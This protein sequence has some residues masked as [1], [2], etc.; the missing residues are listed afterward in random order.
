MVTSA[1]GPDAAGHL[2]DLTQHIPFEMVDE[3]LA[4]TRSAQRR[5]RG[6]LARVVV[7]RLLAGCLFKD[8]GY[9]QAWDRLA[10]GLDGPGV[11]ARRPV[12]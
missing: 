1:S 8:L 7:Y 9:R 11:P 4:E 2:G 12:G 6:L 3:V 10:A 5:I